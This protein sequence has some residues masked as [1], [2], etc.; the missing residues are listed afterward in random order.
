MEVAIEIPE[1]VAQR[2]QG[3]RGDLSRWTLEA[4]AVEAYREGVLTAAEVGRLLG[5]GSR[6]QTETFLHERQAYLHFA[7]DELA[8]DTQAVRDVSGR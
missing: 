5:H 7:A 6:W 1:D 8:G 4:V 3:R 2:L